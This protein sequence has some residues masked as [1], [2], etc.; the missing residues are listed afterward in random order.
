MQYSESD[1][2]DYDDKDDIKQH[3]LQSDPG[4]TQQGN[5]SMEGSNMMLDMQNSQDMSQNQFKYDQQNMMESI[6]EE[7]ENYKD[8]QN[9]QYSMMANE[10]KFFKFFLQKLLR[11][12]CSFFSKI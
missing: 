1:N 4:S 7:Y 6:P 9:Q 11:T 5:M 2:E 8:E 12:N 10:G 3:L